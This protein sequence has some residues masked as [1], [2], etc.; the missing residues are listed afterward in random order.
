LGYTI[1]QKQKKKKR[2]IMGVVPVVGT[3]ESLR[4]VIHS[5]TKTDKG[6]ER[7]KYAKILQNKARNGCPKAQATTAELMGNYLR[8]ESWEA[9]FSL[10]AW[11]EGWKV[12]KEKMAST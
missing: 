7:E 6:R 2:R 9:M 8:R 10:C 3:L 1:A 5:V 4:A 12:L 11:D